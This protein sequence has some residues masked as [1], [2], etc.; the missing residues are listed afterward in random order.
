MLAFARLAQQENRA[1]LHHVDAVVDEKLDGIG[2]AQFLRLAVGHGQEDHGKTLLQLR[3]LVELIQH[4]L[5]LR[6]ALEADHHPHA[7]AVAFVARPFGV[8]VD[9]GDALEEHGLVDLIRKLGDDQRLPILGDVLNGY[10]RPHQEAAAPCAV[11]VHDSRAAVEDAGGREIGPVHVLQHLKQP[12]FGILH[13]LPHGQK[14]KD[15]FLDLL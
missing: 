14:F 3:V 11:R 2:Q 5:R 12:A 7:G 4:N 8:G 10:A 15:A 1:P 6:A 13:Q 9:L